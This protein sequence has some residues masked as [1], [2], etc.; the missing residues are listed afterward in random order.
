M[1]MSRYNGEQVL[2][3]PRAA[4]E[5]VGAFNGVRLNPQDYLAAFLKPGVAHYMDRDLAEE[6]PQFKQIIAYAIFCHQ[7]KVLA[8]ALPKAESAHV[9]LVIE[10]MGAYADTALLRDLLDNYASDNLAALWDMHETHLLQGESSQ[11]SI[12]N[13]GAYIRHV[14]IKDASRNADGTQTYQLIGE[15][16]MPVAEMMRALSSVDYDGFIS[17]EYEGAEDCLTGIARGLQNVKK[18]LEELQ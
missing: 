1:C 18:F 10:T 11:T 13:L 3:V 17:L 8:Y 4:F 9:V 5:A 15:G 2:V 6:S 12:T 14:H 16:T 7:G